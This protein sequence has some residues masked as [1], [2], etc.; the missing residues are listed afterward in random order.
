ML[1]AT[2]PDVARTRD[3]LQTHAA[4]AK[5]T[6][7]QQPARAQPQMQGETKW[8]PPSNLG[9]PPQARTQPTQQHWPPEGGAFGEATRAGAS[10]VN[11]A[12]ALNPEE[13]AVRKEQVDAM[14]SAQAS[15]AHTLILRH[16]FLVRIGCVA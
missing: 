13:M 8:K 6:R 10:S 12:S 1:G 2:H 4:E 3:N 7:E 5:R 14:R 11:D 9:S 16:S 15:E